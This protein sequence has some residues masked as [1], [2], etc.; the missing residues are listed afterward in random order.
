MPRDMWGFFLFGKNGNLRDMYRKDNKKEFYT[1]QARKEGYPARSVYK[2]KEMDEKYRIFKSGNLVLDLGC[3]PGSW[4]L[5]ISEKIG[6]KGRVFGVDIAD[7]KI[8]AKPNVVFLKK[9]ILTLT[10]NDFNGKF[11]VIVSDSAPNTSGTISRDV[12]LSLELSEM[13]FEIVQKFLK[14]GGNFIC[15]IFEG[16]GADEFVKKVE[17]HFSVLKRA[18][19]GAVIKH[20]KEFYIIALGFNK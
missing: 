13:A 11:D 12:G 10:E 8:P 4:L 1:L 5:Y 19:P 3:A 9:D 20:S 7:L 6:E 18:R 14:K 2:L 16:E 17:G 15:K